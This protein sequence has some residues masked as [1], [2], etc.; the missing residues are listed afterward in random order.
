M[1]NF[2]VI[3]FAILVLTACRNDGST[4]QRDATR[5]DDPITNEI[6]MANGYGNFE[7]V[8]QLNFTF[9]VRVNDTV[10][11]QRT[12]NWFPG[13]DRVELTEQGVTSSYVN[14]GDLSEE[15]KAIDQKF[16]NDTYWLLFPYQLVWSDYES[17]HDRNAIAPISK[18][19]M[20]MLSIKYPGEG[21]YTP[22]DTY[23]IFFKDDNMIREWTYESSGGRSL[24]TTWEDY[25]TFNGIT[26]AQMHKSEDESFQ[27]FFTDIDVI[28][29]N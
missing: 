8:R 2:F 22:G 18:E 10:R 13:E 6:A 16:I 5:T 20:Q 24:S 27:L 15:D 12:W 19:P 26:I 4:T 25:E 9:N 7:D 14:R 28:L 1:K 3:I 11:S 21:G 17:E 23:H 29:K